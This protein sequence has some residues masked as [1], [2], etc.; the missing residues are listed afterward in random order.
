MYHSLAFILSCL[1]FGIMMSAQAALVVSDSYDSMAM[2]DR[3]FL[4]SDLSAPGSWAGSEN[5]GGSPAFR[6]TPLA[7]G[8]QYD[9]LQA[10]CSGVSLTPSISLAHAD[11]GPLAYADSASPPGGF[12]VMRTSEE[13]TGLI[14]ADTT[15]TPGRE[16]YIMLI[17]GVSLLG[18]AAALYPRSAN[19]V[20]AETSASDFSGWNKREPRRPPPSTDTP[21]S[22]NFT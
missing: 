10:C 16:P 6:D 15:P 9:F 20:P 5:A 13:A 21:S 12:S 2:L 14:A 8:A 17:V 1:S 11:S 7:D 18:L 3:S 4:S 22:L 19:K